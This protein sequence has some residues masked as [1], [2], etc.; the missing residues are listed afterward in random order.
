MEYLSNSGQ[1]VSLEMSLECNTVLQFAISLFSNLAAGIILA[2]CI[3]GEC[4]RDMHVGMAMSAAS[5]LPSFY[6]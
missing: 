3:G 2:S 4:G 6:M 1:V 5:A